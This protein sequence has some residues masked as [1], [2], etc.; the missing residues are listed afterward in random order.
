MSVRGLEADRH[1]T[2]PELGGPEIR[3]VR[4]PRPRATIEGAASAPPGAD[5]TALWSAGGVPGVMLFRG[6]FVDTRF[7]PHFHEH[8]VVGMT[9]DGIYDAWCGRQRFD[10][11]GAGAVV[12]IPPGVVHTGETVPGVVWR[13]RAFYPVPETIAALRAEL[14]GGRSLP[15]FRD[16]TLR[17]PELSARLL[18]AHLAFER[19]ELLRGGELLTRGLSVLLARHGERVGTPRTSPVEPV[20]VRRTREYLAEHLTENVPLSDLADLADLGTF[21]LLRAFRKAHGMPPHRFLLGLRINRAK[22]LIEAGEHLAAVAAEAGFAD[23]SHLTRY[24]KRC[25]GVTPQAYARA[26]GTRHRAG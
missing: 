24:F 23:Q 5:P 25:V 4:V 11:Y 1:L 2:F 7:P 8:F 20:A 15:G 13:W 16:S 9:L 22:E 26:V 12:V 6:D 14:D 21:R 18:A 3:L 17:D 10:R 19:G